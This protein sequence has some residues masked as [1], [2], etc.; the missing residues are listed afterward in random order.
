MNT[1]V[2]INDSVPA[3]RHGTVQR[4]YGP[5]LR[6]RLGYATTAT[7][8]ENRCRPNAGP[9]Y[10]AV[11][12]DGSSRE[13]NSSGRRTR[14]RNRPAGARKGLEY[15]KPAKTSTLPSRVRRPHAQPRPARADRITSH[16]AACGDRVAPG[17]LSRPARG[18][19][20]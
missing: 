4:P 18:T 19:G 5:C 20:Y 15:M 12:K 13:S 2:E 16:D 7:D 14:C 8:E 9:I 10:Q 6:G 3:V 11:Y 17:R 1:F